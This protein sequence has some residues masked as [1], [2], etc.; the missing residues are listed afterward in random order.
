M[1]VTVRRTL[2]QQSNGN[3]LTVNSKKKQ[4]CLRARRKFLLLF[5]TSF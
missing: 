3:R 2:S 4:K 1:F 5:Y